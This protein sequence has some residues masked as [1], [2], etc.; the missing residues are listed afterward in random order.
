M[1][2]I[3]FIIMLLETDLTNIPWQ[4]KGFKLYNILIIITNKVLKQTLLI[5]SYTIYKAAE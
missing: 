5:P 4:L 2:L 3:N 1:I